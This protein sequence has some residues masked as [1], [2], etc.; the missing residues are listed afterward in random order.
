MVEKLLDRAAAGEQ[1][2]RQEAMELLSIANGSADYYRLLGIANEDSRRRFG[3]R[4]EIYAQIGMEASGCPAN[5]AFCS[6]AQDV[7]DP[8]CSFVL[9]VEQVRQMVQQLAEQGVDEIFLMTTVNFDQEEFLRYGAAVRECMPASMRLVANVGDFDAA[10]ARRLKETGFTGVYHI[11]RLGEGVDTCLDPQQRIRTL[12]AVK[13]AG[14]ALYYCVEPI[15]PEHSYEQI[16]E[17]IFRAREYPVE[18]MAVMKRVCV[19][20]TK[21]HSRGEISAAELAKICAVTTLCVRPSRAMGVHEPDG[22]CLMAGANQIY[23][24]V[25]ANPRDVSLHTENSRGA[26]MEKT[27]QLLHN[28]EWQR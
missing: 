17:E 19:P 6:M 27:L 14:L 16:V 7:F 13:E 15:G 12:D 5:C 11:C 23:T 9:P 22:L 28:A 24:E 2:N 1:L 10:Y 25:S 18:V 26:S 4:G 3:G 8:G 20:G 21:L